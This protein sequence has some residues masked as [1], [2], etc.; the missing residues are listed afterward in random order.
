MI[1]MLLQKPCRFVCPAIS[2]VAKQVFSTWGGAAWKNL[3]WE[4]FTGGLPRKKSHVRNFHGRPSQKK[5]SR[6]IFFALGP[7]WFWRPRSVIF[8]RL[9]ICPLYIIQVSHL[10]YL[11]VVQE[12]WSCGSSD[13]S[14]FSTLFR[15]LLLKCHRNRTIVWTPELL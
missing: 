6:E 12:F 13:V 7:P 2:S 14:P 8:H 11:F 1:L 3:T 4:I 5:I 10:L 9:S 15:W